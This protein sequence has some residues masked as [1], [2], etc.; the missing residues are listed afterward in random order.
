MRLRDLRGEC[1]TLCLRSLWTRRL[2]TSTQ[3]GTTRREPASRR[4]AKARGQ[5]VPQDG[6][7]T[8]GVVESG[9]ETDISFSSASSASNKANAGLGFTFQRDASEVRRER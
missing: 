2:S 9:G 4:E 5:H 7:D 3:R 8:A 1:L 6:R